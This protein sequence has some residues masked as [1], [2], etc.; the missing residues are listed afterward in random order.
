MSRRTRELTAEIERLRADLWT[1]TEENAELRTQ[2]AVL[3]AIGVEQEKEMLM[4][5][6]TCDRIALA[7]LSH[8]H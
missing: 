1:L 8:D 3:E 2:V 5:N 6:R 7:G 4:L